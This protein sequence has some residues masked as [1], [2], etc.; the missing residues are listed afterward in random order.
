[1]CVEFSYENALEKP[2]I[3]QT[4]F[5]SSRSTALIPMY[6][7][8]LCPPLRPFFS[9]RTIVRSRQVVQFTL[10]KNSPDPA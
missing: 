4:C 3:E 5:I 2:D 6:L 9:Q 7:S 10:I 8:L 1:M